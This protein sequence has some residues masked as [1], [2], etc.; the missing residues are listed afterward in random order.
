[1]TRVLLLGGLGQ[2]GTAIAQRWTDCEIVAPSHDELA[3]ERSERLAES[4]AEAQTRRA[5]KRCCL[6]RRRSLRRRGET[7]LEVNAFAVGRAASLAAQ[8]DVLFVTISTDYV[9]DGTKGSPYVESDSP[10]PLSFYGASKLA[11]ERLVEAAGGRA[12]VV[13]TCGLYGSS[14]SPSRRRAFVDRILATGESGEPVRVVADVV[15]SPT[16]AGDLAVALRKLIGTAAYGLYHAA[17]AGPVSWYDFA[18]EA[19]RQARVERAIEPIAAE[20]WKAKAIR[21]RYSALESSKLGNLGIG[22]P[23]WQDGIAAYLAAKLVRPW[24]FESIAGAWSVAGTLPALSSRRWKPSLPLTRRFRS[25]APYCGCSA[26]TGSR[27][28]KFRCPTRSSMRS[29]RTNALAA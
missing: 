12:F 18:C 3:I 1:M 28:K 5:G 16:F 15:A 27:R 25:N 10:N 9:F 2:L 14:R 4:L 13:R 19:M 24:N 22:M 20:Q 7:A 21:P 26:S 6:S 23:S 29:R 11:G 17:A 8:R